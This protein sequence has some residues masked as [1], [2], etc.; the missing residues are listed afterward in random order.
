MRADDFTATNG[1]FLN[2]FHSEAIDSV[3]ER[4]IDI[5]V[6]DSLKL[7]G[8]TLVQSGS[9]GAGRGGAPHIRVAL[10]NEFFLELWHGRE[11][12]YDMAARFFTLFTATVS[13]V[14]LAPLVVWR[15]IEGEPF[16]LV[17]VIAAVNGGVIY[18]F[19]VSD[20]IV[21]GERTLAKRGAA[22]SVTEEAGA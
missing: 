6:R 18:A 14:L 5:A 15:A 11:K 9:G 22:H 10:Q 1:A 20:T 2:S 16:D 12:P 19:L 3:Y 13:G 21:H 8:L 17:Y 7:K 4:G